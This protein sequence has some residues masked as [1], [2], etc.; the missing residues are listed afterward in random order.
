MSIFD[1][2]GLTLDKLDEI[3]DALLEDLKTAFG[4]NI[5]TSDDS[6]FGQIS[7]IISETVSDLSELIQRTKSAFEAQSATGTS[8]SMLVLLNGIE[9]K[10][11]EFSTV[12]LQ[13]TANAAGTTIPAGSE[14]SD[15][16][17]SS[18][19]FATDSE[20]VLA[21]SASGNVSA[22]A[23]ETGAIEAA[24]GTLT[25]IENAVFGWESVTNPSSASVGRREEGDTE[26]RARRTIAA[27]KTGQ[28]SVAAI[29]TAIFN[30][31]AVDVLR[32]YENKG[33]STDANGVPP[34]HIWAIVK[35]GADDDIAK[36][37]FENT[38]A[39]IGFFGDTTITYSDPVTSEDYDITFER[40]EDVG[41]YIEIETEKQ[42]TYPSDG[43]EQI[44]QAIIDFFN[45]EFV[46]S[47]DSLFP[48]F[49]I[50]DNIIYTQLF[51]PINSVSGHYV[52][53]LK[54]GI[55][56][57]PTGTTDITINASQIGVTDETKIT[58]T[59]V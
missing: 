49:G 16:S 38:A 45:G 59:S 39:G 56:P 27:E 11:A 33:S 52:Q 20:L 50:G 48:G 41:I 5:K 18:V 15:P 28:C 32:I 17:D 23:V 35:G 43:D 7:S 46:K 44:K 22:T 10:E 42:S 3:K 19:K 36:A 31:D 8:L 26:L 47:D 21:P 2:T 4:E 37:L 6:V 55:T 1:D 12:T 53:A 40:P 14:V 25:K 13:C 29:Y 51:T 30:I 58:I 9:R 24:N 57:S 34:Q 54:I